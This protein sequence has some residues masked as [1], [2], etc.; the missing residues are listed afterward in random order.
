MNSFAGTVRFKPFKS[1]II[2]S[3]VI[4]KLDSFL[5]SAVSSL[6]VKRENGIPET[7]TVHSSSQI[8]SCQILNLE[9]SNYDHRSVVLL[10]EKT[11]DG[12]PAAYSAAKSRLLKEKRHLKKMFYDK[13]KVIAEFQGA[14][15]CKSMFLRLQTI[16]NNLQLYEILSAD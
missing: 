6:P 3:S 13:V 16:N 11:N 9:S 1:P 15:S 5:S 2:N 8:C 12:T 7:E 4:L 14:G 10:S